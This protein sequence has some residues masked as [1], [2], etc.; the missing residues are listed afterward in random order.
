MMMQITDPTSLANA[1]DAVCET[2]SADNDKEILYLRERVQGK[3][4]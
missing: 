3:I 1:F 4:K 2:D